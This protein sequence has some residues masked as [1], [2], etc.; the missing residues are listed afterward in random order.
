MYNIFDFRDFNHNGITIL[1]ND[2]CELK[3]LQYL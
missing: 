2:F 1:P 3:N